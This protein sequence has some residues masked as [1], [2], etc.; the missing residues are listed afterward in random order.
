MGPRVIHPKHLVFFDRKSVDQS[1]IEEKGNWI[2]FFLQLQIL[3]LRSFSQSSL[4][5]AA[6]KHSFFVTFF[7]LLEMLFI[8]KFQKEKLLSKNP[9]SIDQYT[10]LYSP[11]TT[12]TGYIAIFLRQESIFQHLSSKQFSSAIHFSNS[13][14]KC[15]I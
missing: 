13:A 9:S 6:M 15:I 7:L 1:L 2:S 8:R 11:C 3:S 4:V 5:Y 10:T 14:S 12:T